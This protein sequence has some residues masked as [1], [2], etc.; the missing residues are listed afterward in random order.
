MKGITIN[1]NEAFGEMD[2]DTRNE[3]RGL[4]SDLL[5]G[6][7]ISYEDMGDA[8]LIRDESGDMSARELNE[9]EDILDAAYNR[10]MI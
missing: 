6:Y 7:E 8:Q 9:I 2:Q 10:A 4:V 5:A 3:Y 1:T